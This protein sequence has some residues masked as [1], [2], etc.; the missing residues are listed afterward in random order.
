VISGFGVLGGIAK[1]QGFT[2]ASLHRKHKKTASIL[3]PFAV[4]FNVGGL[5]I[6]AGPNSTT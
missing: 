2:I 6:R 3:Q 5:S 4:N 1:N